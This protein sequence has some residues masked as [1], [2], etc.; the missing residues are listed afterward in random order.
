MDLESI[1][2]FVFTK[3]GCGVRGFGK[4]SMTLGW[5]SQQVRLVN[6]RI[7]HQQVLLRRSMVWLS[8][9]LVGHVNLRAVINNADKATKTLPELMQ[10]ENRTVGLMLSRT[11][12]I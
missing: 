2:L 8:R 5:L 11:F 7:G 9:L 12:N 6:R 1:A 4:S 10:K 3:L